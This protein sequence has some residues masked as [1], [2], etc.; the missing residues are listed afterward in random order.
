MTEAVLESS[1][2]LPSALV[3]AAGRRVAIGYAASMAG[4]VWLG[5]FLRV[6]PATGATFPIG[7]GGLFYV[8]AHA[9]QHAGFM[10]P[11]FVNYNGYNIP[12][13]YPPLGIYA[14]A[15]LQGATGWPML[16]IFLWVPVA[17]TCLSLLAFIRLARVLLPSRQAQ[18][19]AVLAFAVS[20]PAYEWQIKG[21]GMTRSF[22][23]LFAILA[24]AE[25]LRVSRCD[26]AHKSVV[27]G[28]VFSALTILS[29]PEWAAFLVSSAVILWVPELRQQGVPAR[30][31]LLVGLAAAL[32]APWLVLA[33]ARHGIAPF[34]GAYSS[35]DAM[36]PLSQRLLGLFTLQLASGVAF[37]V[38]ASL[39]LAGFAFQWRRGQHVLPAWFVLIYASTSRGSIE[40]SII[41]LALLAG[42]GLAGGLQSLRAQRP[43]GRPLPRWARLPLGAALGAALLLS[44]VANPVII[45]V[46]AEAPLGSS[47]LSAMSWIRHH[48]PRHARILVVSRASWW[49]EN[50][51]SEWLSPLT[52]RLSVVGPQ[53]TEWL[54]GGV[55]ARLNTAYMAA[56]ECVNRSTVCVTELHRA[57]GTIQYVYVDLAYP[58]DGI[59]TYGYSRSLQSTPGLDLVYENAGIRIFRWT[60]D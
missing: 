53:G 59:T 11:S 28:A 58:D 3:S 26:R 46:S 1:E 38:V 15:V 34:L 37:P 23:F 20:T 49:G 29:H 25:I 45:D 55:F 5:V 2:G 13:D 6:L 7:D 41:P 9:V 36:D 32:I 56:Y 24:L 31:T 16:G 22:G 51:E 27:L 12:F 48:T 52:G 43:G 14:A 21:G 10:L 30:L 54:R 4:V 8:M 57:Y 17:V 19:F 35:G 50:Y 18:A 47:Q 39:G 42:I 60:H 40:K 33:V 44:A